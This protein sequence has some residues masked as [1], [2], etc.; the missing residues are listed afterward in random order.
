MKGGGGGGVRV[1]LWRLCAAMHGPMGDVLNSKQLRT[2]LQ[3]GL[4]DAKQRIVK[5]ENILRET[6]VVRLIYNEFYD[7]SILEGE[8]VKGDL[9][10]S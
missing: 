6:K 8:T 5:K 7:F 1:G 3:T 10:Y 4:R 9:V 2:R